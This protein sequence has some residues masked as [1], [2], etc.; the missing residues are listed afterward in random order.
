MNAEE[1]GSAC[2][3]L[4][5]YHCELT[6]PDLLGIRMPSYVGQTCHE[7]VDVADKLKCRGK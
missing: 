4:Y 7:I 5:S 6:L 3:D 1:S 2:I